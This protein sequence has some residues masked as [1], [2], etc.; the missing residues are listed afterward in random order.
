MIRLKILISE[1]GTSLTKEIV[2]PCDLYHELIIFG[3]A[4]QVIHYDFCYAMSAIKFKH[5]IGDAKK[6]LALNRLL[7]EFNSECP[8]MTIEYLEEIMSSTG[9]HDIFDSELSRK[10]IENDYMMEFITD[11][12]MSDFDTDKEKCAHHLAHVLRIPFAKN[13]TV[14]QF[15][16]MAGIYK[17]TLNWNEVWSYY[18][19]MGFN[20]INIEDEMF[21]LHWG[22]AI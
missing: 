9:I 10:I 13:V 6:I 14:D 4:E 1:Y 16:N 21:I 20:I 19:Q 8:D 12:E 17:E 3:G 11:E 7:D 2:L 5:S 22:N 18:E 15:E